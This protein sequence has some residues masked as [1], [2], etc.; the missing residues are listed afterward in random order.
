MARA[1]SR[2]DRRRRRRHAR[3]SISVTSRPGLA[4]ELDEGEARCAR[5]TP[6]SIASSPRRAR[7]SR[8]P[9]SRAGAVDALY[10]TGGSTGLDILSERLRAGV[11]GARLVRGDRF[12]S[13]ATGL[14]LFAQRRF[15]GRRRALILRRAGRPGSAGEHRRHRLR[16][17]LDVAAVQAGDAHAARAH[18]VDRELLAQAVDLRGVRPV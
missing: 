14:A 8:R 9:G 13:V 16:R 11:P 1:E 15:A 10:F 2:E 17:R 18:Q 5:S 3:R 4:A 6:T 12:A 7:P